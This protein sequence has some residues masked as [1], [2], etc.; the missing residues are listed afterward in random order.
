MPTSTMG[1]EFFL[2]PCED[3]PE[4]QLVR[5]TDLTSEMD[6]SQDGMRVIGIATWVRGTHLTFAT[7][8][9]EHLQLPPTIVYVAQSLVTHLCF[10]LRT[11]ARRLQ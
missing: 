2:L 7:R 10:W 9:R 1:N 11:S 8:A 4:G 5:G 3:H 6:S